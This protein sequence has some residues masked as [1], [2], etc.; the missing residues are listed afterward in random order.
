[1][2]GYQVV[3]DKERWRQ[4]DLLSAIAPL[5][6]TA[7]SADAPPPAKAPAATPRGPAA[8]AADSDSDDSDDSDAPTA[9]AAPAGGGTLREVLRARIAAAFLA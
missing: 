6:N 1:M 5:P 9:A 3:L 4:Q 2:C 7:P 8:P